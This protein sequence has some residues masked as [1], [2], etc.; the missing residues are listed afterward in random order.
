MKIDC[1][2][3]KEILQQDV[4]AVYRPEEN[5]ILTANIAIKTV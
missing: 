5:A 3:E 1:F 2:R 4:C